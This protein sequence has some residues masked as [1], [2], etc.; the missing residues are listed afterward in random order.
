L[1]VFLVDAFV[2]HIN[3]CIQDESNEKDHNSSLSSIIENQR[4]FLDLHDNQS[5]RLASEV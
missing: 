1:Y 4:E 3:Q 5:S 2:F